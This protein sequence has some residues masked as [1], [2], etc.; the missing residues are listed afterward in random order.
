M[1]GGESSRI[2][3]P[4]AIEEALAQASEVSGYTFN[5]NLEQVD[6]DPRAHAVAVHAA[7]ED[8]DNTVLVA[9]D[10]VGHSLEIVTG[11][12]TQ[13]TLLDSECQFAMATMLSS[14]R[15][16]DLTG[17][18]RQG[19]AQLGEAARSLPVRHARSSDDF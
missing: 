5:V 16:G 6:G 11:R 18:L 12:A 2:I 17:G 9:C 13:R 14:F 1:P 19:I 8:P 3:D 4:G 10:P 7:T 15:N